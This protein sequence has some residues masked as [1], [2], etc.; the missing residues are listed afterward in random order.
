MS[1]VRVETKRG[2]TVVSVA[3]SLDPGSQPQLDRVFRHLSRVRQYNILL[4]AKAV[5]RVCGTAI[6]KLQAW[7]QTLQD[8]GGFL[9]VVEPSPSARRDLALH[10]RGSMVAFPSERMAWHLVEHILNAK[11][12]REMC[13]ETHTDAKTGLLNQTYVHTCWAPTHPRLGED[14]HG[15]VLLGL[16]EAH[17]LDFRNEHYRDRI[18][19][20]AAKRLSVLCGRR[21]LLIRWGASSFLVIARIQNS[22]AIPF[23][24]RVMSALRHPVKTTFEATRTVV[25]SFGLVQCPLLVD[26]SLTCAEGLRLV[27]EAMARAKTEGGDRWIAA[28]STKRPYPFLSGQLPDLSVLATAG[29]IEIHREVPLEEPET[30]PAVSKPKTWVKTGNSQRIRT[31]RTRLKLLRRL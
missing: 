24:G 11:L 4:Q 19:V 30:H 25:W 27:V 2:A 28:T 20:E 3:G 23:A 29:L 12:I 7:S 9:W 1:S 16:I 18:M 17:G 14:E 10:T 13:R 21:D 6:T 22:D 8:R 31:R 26:R 15:P 5:D